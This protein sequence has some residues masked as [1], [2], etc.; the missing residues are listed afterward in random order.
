MAKVK[1]AAVDFQLLDNGTAKA[2]ATPQDSV[3]VATT[4][5]AGTSTPTWA[6]SDPGVVVAPDPSDASG[7]TAIV[8]PA[9]PPVLVTGAVI[10]VSAT[11][12]DGTTVITGSG[13]PIDVI[14]GGPT[15][16][17]VVES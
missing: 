17:K 16:F 6:S 15:G 10:S 12:P 7:L 13:D 3:G 1:D 2:V 9:T 5:P 8:S 11:L 14:A 4:L